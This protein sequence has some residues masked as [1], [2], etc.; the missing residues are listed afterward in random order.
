MPDVDAKLLKL[1]KDRGVPILTT[2]FNLNRL[3]R[4]QD[5]QVLNVNDL[6]NALKPAVL[7]G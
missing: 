4:I 6:A 3:A 5:V 1:A 2:D 7:P